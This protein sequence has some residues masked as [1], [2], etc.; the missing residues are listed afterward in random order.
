[1]REAEGGGMLLYLMIFFVTTIMLV[2]VGILA[3]TKAYKAKNRI[4]EIVE[5][6]DCGDFGEWK[7][8]TKAITLE[9]KDSLKDMGYQI[10]DRNYKGENLGT[11]Y[12]FNI[13]YTPANRGGYYKVTTF[14]HL[15][16]PIVGNI[17]NMAVSGETKIM[18]K[19]CS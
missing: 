10:A 3:Y 2:F 1:M 9:I 6:Y 5:S 7:T 8:G 14:I 16:F 12:K 11:G 15:D 4:I 13:S 18:N 19:N 17:V